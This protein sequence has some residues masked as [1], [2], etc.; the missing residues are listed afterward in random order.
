MNADVDGLVDNVALNDWHPSRKSKGTLI[1]FVALAIV[2]LSLLIYKLG[3]SSV[4][5]PAQ[6][7]TVEAFIISPSNSSVQIPV[8]LQ[9]LS[10]GKCGYLIN[11]KYVFELPY[12]FTV[13]E[14]LLPQKAVLPTGIVFKGYPVYFSVYAYSPLLFCDMY[15]R[16]NGS[17]YYLSMLTKNGT[18]VRA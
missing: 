8:Y 9:L 1:V 3:A 12:N 5:L 17:F 2:V 14:S 15:A 4:A 13:D 18:L 16:I 7:K 11:G 10:N 6:N